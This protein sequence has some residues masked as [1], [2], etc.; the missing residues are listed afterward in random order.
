VAAYWERRRRPV[1]LQRSGEDGEGRETWLAKWPKQYTCLHDEKR[2]LARKTLKKRKGGPD[3]AKKGIVETRREA[4]SSAFTNR[5]EVYC[6]SGGTPA[7]L[8]KKTKS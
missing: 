6:L 4:K 3:G 1:A 7:D 5:R 8:A 2:K